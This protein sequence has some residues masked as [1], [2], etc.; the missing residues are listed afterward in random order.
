MKCINC[1]CEYFEGVFCPECGTKHI[2]NKDTNDCTNI[3]LEGE[4][5]AKEK[6]EHEAEIAR[7][8]TEQERLAIERLEKETELARLKVEQEKEASLRAVEKERLLQEEK[9]KKAEENEKK[10][11]ENEG[12]TMAVCSLIMGIIALVSFGCLFIP[13]ILGVIFA[14]NGKK[15]GKM[16]KSAK[17]GLICSII[18]FIIL[19]LLY[20]I[21]FLLV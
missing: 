8:K 10:R 21:A 13:E 19:A 18:S 7:Q 9:V 12:R 17:V 2:D 3:K 20:V 15:Q 6:A 16:R 11:I 4:R 14:L 5:L 1:G